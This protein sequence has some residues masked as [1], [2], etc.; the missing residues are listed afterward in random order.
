MSSRRSSSKGVFVF[1]LG[2]VLAAA[3]AIHGLI[4]TTYGLALVVETLLPWTWVLLVFLALLTLIRLSWFSVAGLLIPCLVW[5]S[6]F[7]AFLR[8]ASPPEDP[9]LLVATH[10]VGARLPQPT[11]TA[12]SII[13]QEPDIVAIQEIESLSGQIITEEL[14]EAYPH[15]RKVESVGVWSKWPMTP[16]EEYT[17]GM[18]WTR[19]FA[20]TISTDHGD[21]RFYAVHLPSV[22]PGHESLRNTGLEQLADV[23]AADDAERI[24]V[25]GDFNT[26][27]SDRYFAELDAMLEDTRQATG[28]G[29]GYTWPAI[30]PVTRL[31]HIMVG[32]ALEPVG[33]EVLDRGT[34]DHRAVIGSIDLVE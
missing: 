33:D 9:D 28:G 3:L 15:A 20:T 13:D 7:G 19:A 31:D 34:S 6:M 2:A 29:F 32:G 8:P 5:G 12:H 24:V 1:V 21:I 4:P 25:A 14:S 18:Q 11:A 27:Y 17:L 23:I 22:R 10:N 16:P 26:S 30:L